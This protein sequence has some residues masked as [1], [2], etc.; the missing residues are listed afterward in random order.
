MI[1]VSDRWSIARDRSHNS[2][3]SDGSDVGGGDG[4][5]LIASW[6]GDVRQS[7]CLHPNRLFEDVADEAGV[8]EAAAA[9]FDADH[10]GQL[11]ASGVVEVVLL[12]GRHRVE[13]L[14]QFVG[15]VVR[16]F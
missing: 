9:W 11:R 6:G 8:A 5:E 12:A 7:D 13:D 1:R 16:E 14:K 4:R 3:L 2:G 15:R 10:L